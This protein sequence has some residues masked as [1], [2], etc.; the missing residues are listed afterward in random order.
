MKTKKNLVGFLI[1]A[2]IIMGAGTAQSATLT[3]SFPVAA[4]VKTR[5]TIGSATLAFGDVGLF[6]A[7][8][9]GAET[10]AAGNID[11]SATVSVYCPSGSTG[12]VTFDN[13]LNPT[14]T[15]YRQMKSATT[16]DV[17]PYHLYS[18]SGRMT[19][20]GLTGA[21]AYTVVGTGT[22]STFTVYGRVIRSQAPN[23]APATDYTDTVTMTITY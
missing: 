4:I 3:G 7:S 15:T 16:S 11:A 19:E 18:D 8:G 12:T 2:G 9:T 10:Y 20:I 6:T 17:I 14:G 13:G 1:V 23:P 22:S 21:T 5:C